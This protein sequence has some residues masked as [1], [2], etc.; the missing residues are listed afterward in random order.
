M[1]AAHIVAMDKNRCIG[2]DGQ[3]PWKIKADLRNFRDFTMHETVVAGNN[4][5]TTLP[6]L[7]GR[8]L[9]GV[10]QRSIA[11]LS[12]TDLQ[13]ALDQAAK[14]ATFYMRPWYYII[15][16]A[17]IYTATLGKVDK[18]YIT[19][20]D[21]EVAGDTYYPEFEHLFEMVSQT[22]WEEENGIKFRFTLWDRKQSIT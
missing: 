13:A 4:T 14:Y 22:P 12:F 15:G 5:L 8:Y 9:I 7:H 20:V 21:L 11:P 6:L 2:K 18:L 1:K 10:G 3:L 16:G 17:Q 19:Q